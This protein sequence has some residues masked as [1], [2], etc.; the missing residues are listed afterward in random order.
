MS[1]CGYPL[2]D[3]G[4]CP[5][6]QYNE[7]DMCFFKRQQIPYPEEPPSAT[8]PDLETAM[9]AWLETY[10]VPPEWHDYWKTD[11]VEV[12]VNESLAY[13]A[14][15]Y[16]WDGKRRLE[17]QPQYIN[18]GVIAHE[19]AHNSYALLSDDEKGEWDTLYLTLV[20]EFKKL[21]SVN[22]YG[23]TSPVECHAEIYR[24][25]GPQMRDGL[26]LFYPKLF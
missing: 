6:H 23:K 10:A 12:I 5:W 11:G 16:D 15:A 14:M 3:C 20:K 8:A 1:E 19:Q 9:A 2:V 24:Y 4:H 17:I 13:P 18:A 25:Y 7:C 26:K 22:P 21:W